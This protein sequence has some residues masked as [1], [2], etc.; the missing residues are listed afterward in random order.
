MP[1]QFSAAHDRERIVPILLKETFK[2]WIDRMPGVG[3]KLIIVGDVQVPTTGW[4]VSLVRHS[5]QGFNPNILI[6]DVNAQ[7]PTGR[8]GDMISIVPVRYEERPPRN[9]YTQVTVVDGTD[10]VTIG[11]GST[12]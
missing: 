8:A 2:A 7:Q 11:V 5:P 6:V 9:E 1:P 3:P 10:E 12:Q 4:H